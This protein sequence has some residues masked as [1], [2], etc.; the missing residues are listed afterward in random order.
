MSGGTCNHCRRKPMRQRTTHSTPRFSRSREN[1]LSRPGVRRTWHGLPRLNWKMTMAKT[2]EEPSLA[3]YNLRGWDLSGGY[4]PVMHAQPIQPI[5]QPEPDATN[6][7]K[8]LAVPEPT[9]WK[10]LCMVPDV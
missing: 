7:E 9:G 10:I 8:N 2:I 3:E 1:S 4:A 5:E 6:E